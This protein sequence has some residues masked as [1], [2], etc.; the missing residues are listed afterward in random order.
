MIPP[1]RKAFAVVAALGLL[2]AL[3]TLALPLSTNLVLLAANLYVAFCAWLVIRDGG[4]AEVG[5]FAAGYLVLFVL[6]LGVLERESL[7]L[8][9]SLLYASV[10]RVRLLLGLFG[11]FALSYVV[12]QPYA[13]ETFVPLAAAFVAV[14]E[15]H[16]RGAPRFLQACLGLGLLAFGTLLLPVLHLLVEDS[17]KTLG[18]VLEREDVQRALSLSLASS[19]AATGI[20]LCF[21]VP[22]GYALARGQFRGKAALE[23]AVDLPILIP[24]SVVGLALL[25][26]LGPGSPLGAALESVG[27]GPSGRLAG[28]IV[29]QVFVASPFLV[30]AAQSAFEA[31]PEHLE[32]VSRTLGASPGETFFRV[33]LPLAARGIFV[34]ITLAWA[35]AIS[36]FGALLLFAPNPRTAPILC[37]DEFLRAGL[38]E[39]RPIAVLLLLVCLWVFVLLQYGKRF[40]PAPLSGRRT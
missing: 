14:F 3:L 5:L 27:L 26:I 30:K 9:L 16:R 40:L 17:P 28:V 8:L 11:A 24:Q 4:L 6:V 38:V 21:G 37:H 10:F 39:A 31:V 33:S 32:S 19:S 23:A 35:R 25:A 1:L 20:V 18:V 36:E 12:F 29:A 7:F 13:F 34:G 22:L 15:L 2:H